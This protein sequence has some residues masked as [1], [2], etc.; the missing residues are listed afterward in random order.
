MIKKICFRAGRRVLN[1]LPSNVFA[2]LIMTA[3]SAQLIWGELR[4]DPNAETQPAADKDAKASTPDATV[5]FIPFDQLPPDMM[6]GLADALDAMFQQS[7]GP[8]E[9]MGHDLTHAEKMATGMYGKLPQSTPD[10]AGEP[11]C[12][13]YMHRHDLFAGDSIFSKN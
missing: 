13:C 4:R 7:P 5:Q 11:E 1:A 2:A 3:A 9:Q 6:A 12:D 8:M 10:E